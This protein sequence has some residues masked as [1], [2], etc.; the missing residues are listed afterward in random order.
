MRILAP[1][2]LALSLTFAAVPAAAA[3]VSVPAG[4]QVGVHVVQTLSS[5]TATVGTPFTFVAA[6]NVI[7]NNHV[8]IKKGAN[9]SGRVASVEK[10]HGKSAGK[11]SLQLTSVHAVDG[12]LVPLSG[13]HGNMHG[14]PEK[15]KASTATVAATILLGPIGLFAHNMVKG[16]DVTVSP[17]HTIQAWVASTTRVNA[18]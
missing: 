14:N 10:A 7:V 15:G 18:P 5:G 17:D 11:M 4:T 8:V 16:K 6:T 9:G 12:T 1:S 13:T 3:Q 2:I